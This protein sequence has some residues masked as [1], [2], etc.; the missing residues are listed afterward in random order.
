MHLNRMKKNIL[1][2]IAKK[3]TPWSKKKKDIILIKLK[4]PQIFVFL[5]QRSGIK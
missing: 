3:S 2:N 4:K 1:H 5:D